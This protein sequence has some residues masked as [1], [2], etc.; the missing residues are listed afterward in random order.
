MSFQKNV[1]ETCMEKATTSK[2]YKNSSRGWER[3]EKYRKGVI[4]H[5]F[6]VQAEADSYNKQALKSQNDLSFLFKI[7]YYSLEFLIFS[8]KNKIYVTY[9]Y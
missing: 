2:G 9:M 6:W 4:I 3:R 8:S 5:R 1:Q 7:Y